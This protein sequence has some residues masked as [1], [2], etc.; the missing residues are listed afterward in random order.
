MMADNSCLNFWRAPTDNDY[1]A[2]LQ[3]KYR[4]W[5]E[6]KTERTSFTNKQENGTIVVEA[7][8]EMCLMYLLNYIWTY[9]INNTGDKK[10]PRKWWLPVKQRKCPIFRFGMQMQMPDEFYRINYLADPVENYSD[11]NHATDLGIYR[12]TVAEQF[13]HIRPRNGY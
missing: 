11:R 12:Q 2:R 10:L 5:F 3:H 4:V 1:G 13:I 7:G 9:V 8:Y 6:S